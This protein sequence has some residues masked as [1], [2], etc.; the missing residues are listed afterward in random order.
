MQTVLGITVPF[1]ALI[2]AGYV[3]ARR[4]WVPG[5][6]VPAFNGFLLYFAVPAML[7]RFA[8]ALPFA[9]L[10]NGRL[11]V[12]WSGAG[13]AVLLATVWAGRRIGLGLRDAAFFG[14]AGSVG[15]VGFLG[16]PLLVALMG[17]RAAAPAIVAI[18]ADLVALS[19]VGLAIAHRDPAGDG[20]R[21]PGVREI[22]VRVLL[23]PL[24]VAMCAGAAFSY[25]GWR[26]WLPLEEFVRLLAL[27]A[28]PCALFAIG[29]SLVRPD[30][31]LPS[32]AIAPPTAAK[33]LVPPLAA[34]AAVWLAGVEPFAARVAFLAA[35]LPS[36]GWV[37]IFAQGHKADAGRIAA[38][39]LVTT[40]L[41]FVTFSVLVWALGVTPPAP[42]R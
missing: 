30:P 10:A 31:P 19:S 14:L 39:I 13:L 15:N 6:A 40:A 37:F 42:A 28:G 8:S 34:R 25:F 2:L 20:A 11:L 3:A 9:E 7:F 22:A 24:L 4:S 27:A 23:N 1:F 38:T 35:A 21:G 16:V 5:D 41:A 33:L 26:L 36:A 17:E 18:V 29:V 32:P 12:A